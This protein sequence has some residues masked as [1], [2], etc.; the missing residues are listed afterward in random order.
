MKKLE[1]VMPE[2]LLVTRKW[3]KDKVLTTRGKVLAGSA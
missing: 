1:E 3:L 2:E